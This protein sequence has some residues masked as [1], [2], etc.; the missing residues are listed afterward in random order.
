MHHQICFFQADMDVFCK[1]AIFAVQPAHQLYGKEKKA[2]IWTSNDS[3]KVYI[4][5]WMVPNSMRLRGSS[6]R[7]I[8]IVH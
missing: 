3:K 1:K 2:K 5:Q 4:D 8:K 6:L 7:A